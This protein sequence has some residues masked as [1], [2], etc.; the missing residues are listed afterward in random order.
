MKSTLHAR[1]FAA[2]L[3]IFCLLFAPISALAKKGEKNYKRGLQ[4]EAAQ[5]WEQAAQEF[6][7]AVAADP[8]NIEYQLHYRRALFNA[9]QVYMQRGR[10]LA[11]RGDYVGAYNAFRQAYGYDPANEL[12]KSEMDRM[13]RLQREKTGME[14]KEG[15][16]GGVQTSPA[17]YQGD[18]NGQRARG[19]SSQ[20]PSIPLRSEQLRVI[21]FNGDLLELIRSLADEINLNVIFDRDL[22][23][24]RRTI[25]I[26]N[27]RNVTAAQAL[28]YIFLSQGLFFQK[29]D[30]RTILVADQN[31]RNQ[32]QQLVIR[33]FYLRNIKPEDA[34]AVIQAALPPQPGRPVMAI[35]PSQSTNSLTVRDTPENIRLISQII[36]SIDKDR[37][38]VVM[39]VNIYEVSQSDL[40]QLGNQLGTDTTLV[41]LGG[42]QRGLTVVGGSREVVTQSLSN[43]PTAL[44]AALIVPASAIAALQSKAHTRLLASTQVHAFDGEESETRIGQRVPVQTAQVPYYYYGA[45][46]SNQTSQPGGIVNP[47][48]FPGGYPVINFEPTGL[49]LK[50]TPQVFP[51][52]DVQ[53]KMTIESKDVLNP[54]TLT[55]TFTER[56]IKG[57]ARIQNNRTMML[58]SIA[59]DRQSNGRQGLP[60]LGLIPVLGRFFTAPRRDD[61]QTD[62]VIAVT[63]H[64]L[65]APQVTPRDE[66]LRPSGTQMMPMTESLASLVQEIEREELAAA[67]A[68][69]NDAATAAATSTGAQ[70]AHLVQTNAL[71]TGP[72]EIQTPQFIPAPKILLGNDG[73]PP[74]RTSVSTQPVSLSGQSDPSVVGLELKSDGGA[75][76]RVGERRRIAL[77]LKSKAPVGLAMVTLRFDP[78]VLAVRAVA[79]GENF[80]GGGAHMTNT[81]DPMGRLVLSFAPEV[82]K[83]LSGTGT[84]VYIEVEA[85]GKGEAGIDFD[86]E[87]THLVAIDGRR[88][89]PQLVPAIKCQIMQ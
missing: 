6:A 59:Q 65:R 38:E 21:N 9:S 25:N 48:L 11:E 18:S 34:R 78:K 60:L 72:V 86:D 35:A 74:R 64:V 2:L 58:A 32:Y 68:K 49:T 22:Q 89:V 44:G 31:K 42:I 83:S 17:V 43:V 54:G 12:A 79:P 26:N 67:Q 39:D 23:N 57:T 76:M 80:L 36:E 84:L 16:E 13:L 47:G 55:P 27:L 63:P 14:P 73:D 61:V 33:T 75:T 56:S 3:M 77:L 69:R 81:L 71:R 4:Y 19:A 87:R 40:L 30:R 10:A 53:V 1:S 8:S 51:N 15:K 85:I 62:I 24:Q 7:L 5:Q 41:N 66:E 37:A 52:M 88:I 45:P 50:F 46:T 70:T 29:L 20:E 82:G 28:D